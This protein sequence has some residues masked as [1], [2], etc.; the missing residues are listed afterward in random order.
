MA[1]I[2]I[3]K[4]NFFHNL[5]QIALKTGSADKIAVVLKDNAY[6]HGLE[7]MAGLAHDF[8]IKHAVVKNAKEAKTIRYLF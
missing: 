7:L 2:T 4:E 3:S 8:G 6:G 5:N 1:T